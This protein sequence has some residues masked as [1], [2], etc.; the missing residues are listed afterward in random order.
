MP[1]ILIVEDDAPLGTALRDGF[2]YEGYAVAVARDGAAG[3]KLASEGAP[4][5][6]LLDVMLPKLSGVDVCTRLRAA[7]NTVPIIMLTARGQEIDRVLGLKSGADDYVTKPFSF[8]ELTAR[9]EA[10]LRR[11][12]GASKRDVVFRFGDVEADFAKCEVLKAGRRVEISAREL[13]LLE[14][15]V[16]HRGDVLTR[17]RLL[18]AVWSYEGNTLSRTVDVHVAKLRRKLED[19][20]DDPRHILTVHGIG[21][22]F[23]S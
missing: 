10:V 9:V 7:G 23:A 4:D 13:R 18:A 1:K 8:M 22:K 16:A 6:V 12:G 19:R 21:Y 3:L 20:P 2:E 15:L 11:A 5:V 14:Y 17:E